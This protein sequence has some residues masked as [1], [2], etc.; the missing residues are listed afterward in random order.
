MQ[1]EYC[2]PNKI[3]NEYIL[4]YS[5]IYVL[6]FITKHFT[7]VILAK[8]LPNVWQRRLAKTSIAVYEISSVI[9]LIHTI[10]Y[11]IPILGHILSKVVLRQGNMGHCK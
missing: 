10:S 7:Q 11:V 6:G 9:C 3:Y 2:L 5:I 8:V 4:L 1:S